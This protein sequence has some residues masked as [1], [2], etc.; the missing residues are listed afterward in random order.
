MY[1]VQPL[2]GYGDVVF[3]KHGSYYTAYGNLSQI[4][5]RIGTI[6]KKGDHVGLSGTEQTEMGEVLFFLLREEN[7]FVNPVPWLSSK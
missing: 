4:D 3:V 6:L 7:S 1:A 2:P 5:V